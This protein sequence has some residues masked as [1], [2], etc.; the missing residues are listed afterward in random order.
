MGR[1]AAP[2]E[3]TPEEALRDESSDGEVEGPSGADSGADGAAGQEAFE[4]AL[5]QKD[6]Q[7][8]TVQQ[9]LLYQ[10]AEFENFRKRTEKRY[11]DA[12]D[13]ATEPFTKELLPVVDNLDRAVAHARD[14]GPQSLDALVEGVGHVLSQLKQVLTNHGV[15]E[16]P[17]QGEKFDPNVHESLAQL[18]G[19]ADNLVLEVYEKGYLLKGRLLRPAKVVIS[20]IATTAGDG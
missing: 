20:K 1:K 18:P 6:A 12:L 4:A 3:S 13:F 8:A 11:R 9:E 2:P 10:R 15:C 16:V 19:D 5:A 7:L 14:A 17:A